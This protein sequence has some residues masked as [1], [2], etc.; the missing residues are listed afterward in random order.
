MSLDR[1]KNTYIIKVFVRILGI[2]FVIMNVIAKKMKGT[3]IYKGEIEE[4]NLWESK[5]VIFV[6]NEKDEENAD[7]IKGHLEFGGKSNYK[8]VFY[9]KY[10]KRGFDVFLSF[11]GL[12]V[13]FPV[14]LG[15]A[16]AIIIEDPGPVFFVQ[17]RVGKNKKYFKLHKFRTMKV[18]TPHDVPTHQLEDPEKYI[19]KVGKFLRAH[20]LDE[21]PQ[22]WDIF[23]GNMSIIGPR[24]ALWNQDFLIAER[25][26]Y[27]ANEVKPGLTGWAQINGRDKLEISVKARLDG[28]YVQKMGLKQDIICF[29]ASFGIIK[30]DDS[31]I[32]GKVKKTIKKKSN[33]TNK[34]SD[35]ELIGNIGFG[36]PVVVNKELHKNVLITGADSYIGES[37]NSYAIKYYGENFNI[38]II[39]MLNDSWRKKDFSSYDIVYHVAGIAHSDIEDINKVTKKKY[40][41]VNTALA[42]EV[43]KKAKDDGVK[44]FILMS[45]MIVYGNPAQKGRK[46]V[47]DENSIPKPINCYGNSKFQADVAVRE[48]ADD[49][50]KV[51]VLRPPMIYGKNSKGNYSVLADLSKKLPLFPN[52]NNE[53]SMIYIDNFCELLC[54]IMLVEKYEKSAIVLLPQNKEWSKTSDMVK[55]IAEIS[56]NKIKILNGISEKFVLFAG[57]M[58]GKIGKL[59]NKAFGNFV[60]DYSISKYE[61]I[62]YQKVSLS[63]SISIIENNETLLCNFPL[64]KDELSKYSVLMSVYKNDNAR[65]L[66][67]AIDSM[68]KQTI[69][70]EQFIIVEDGPISE[71]LENVIAKYEHEYSSLFTIIRLKKNRGLGNAL[72]HGIKICRNELIARMDADD[73]SKPE[74]CEKQLEYFKLHPETGIVGTQIS[75]F[76]GAPGKI[77]ASR[78]VPCDMDS[79]KKFSRKRSPFNH[80]TV[81]YRKSIINML[82]GYSL[83]SRKE[84]LDFFIRAINYNVK[85]ANLDEKL[86]LYRTSADNLQRRK[87]WIN[88]KEYINIMY[89]FYKKKYIGYL[90]LMYV[91]FG[92]LIMYS[93]PMVVIKKL[94]KIFLKK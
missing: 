63:D 41:E 76:I 17:K 33:Y 9:D 78:V 91:V 70:P 69:A 20:S 79:I 88:C 84:D 37:F 29:I 74:R 50:F 48:F 66:K 35:E 6:R 3:S 60:Y 31:V 4:Q 67:M 94:D 21:L 54:Q 53:R 90:D 10:L 62:D 51:I 58:P 30:H 23:I 73:I 27:E 77:I 83:Y 15:I 36:E 61:G 65:Y 2:I 5:K 68:L 59:I 34:K 39:D 42:V 26:K 12:I 40:F 11:F 71:K 22:I 44:K 72:N 24:P 55:Q 38:D 64:N 93:M 56:G 87:S 86:L 47:I 16:F 13:L 57:K 18:S 14:M 81:M 82:H 49:K 52:I 32:E 89:G 1:K 43:C 75:E 92:Q 8:P 7:G 46:K 28:E 25:D 45:S 80:P 85:V 19:T